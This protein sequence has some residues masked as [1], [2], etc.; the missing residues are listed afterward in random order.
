MVESQPRKESDMEEEIV[1]LPP[2]QEAVEELTD[3]KGDEPDA[4]KQPEQG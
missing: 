1:K 4:D 2:S 3:G